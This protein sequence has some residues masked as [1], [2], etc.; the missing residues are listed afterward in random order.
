MAITIEQSFALDAPPDLV[1]SVLTDPPRVVGC[2]PG[3]AITAKIDDRTWEGTMT[4]K[5]GPVAAAY[6]GKV[7]FERLDAG[8]GETELWGQGQETRGKGSAEMRMRCRL[9]AAGPART[10][11]A[12]VTDFTVTGMLAQFGRGMIQQV[13]DGMLRQFSAQIRRVLD[14]AK[15]KYGDVVKT[16]AQQF[17]KLFPDKVADVARSAGLQIQA[18]GS[19]SAASPTDVLRYVEAVRKIGGDVA[20]TSARLT[21]RSAA[22]REN[23]PI[24]TL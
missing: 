23:L 18:D 11:V 19:N 24:P 2:L 6:R 12:L 20:Y 4:V 17:V 9:S 10:Q 3:A 1:W 15:T 13:S 7:R 5:V 8:G 16:H 22:Q 14:G 21:I